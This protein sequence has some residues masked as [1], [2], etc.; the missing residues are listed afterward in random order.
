M[1]IYD[2]CRVIMMVVC[3]VLCFT[4]FTGNCWESVWRLTVVNSFVV[5]I[6]MGVWRKMSRK[7]NC[8]T[9]IYLHLWRFWSFNVWRMFF[10]L[11]LPWW[12]F[13]RLEFE[14]LQYVLCFT[15]WLWYFLFH[16]IDLFEREKSSP[17]NCS[18]WRFTVINGFVFFIQMCL[19]CINI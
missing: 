17:L 1:F 6:Q 15:L 2:D 19:W 4:L 16:F 11:W 9:Y 18:V 8:S 7:H 14:G 13:E 10:T 12:Y 5:F 3:T